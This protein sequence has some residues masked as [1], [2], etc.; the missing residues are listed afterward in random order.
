VA[1]KPRESLWFMRG[2]GWSAE[3]QARRD[4]ICKAGSLLSRR[5]IDEA[6]PFGLRPQRVT[7]GR[8]LE[9]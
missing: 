2:T 8:A 4:Y 9:R 5:K 6:L 1:E 7:L 3:F